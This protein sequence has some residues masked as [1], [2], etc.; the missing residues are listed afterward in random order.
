VCYLLV[1]AGG[2]FAALALLAELAESGAIRAVIDRRF[3]LAEAGA[4]IGYVGAR[5]ARGKVVID[6]AEP[7]GDR[8]RVSRLALSD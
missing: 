6:C 1:I 7:Q 5:R 2:V 4:A 3:P 8:A